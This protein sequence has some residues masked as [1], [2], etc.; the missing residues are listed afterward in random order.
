MAV[1]KAEGVRRWNYLTEE[2]EPVFY[3]V[4]SYEEIL[5]DI[6]N[7]NRESDGWNKLYELH[8]EEDR[9]Y[10]DMLDERRPSVKK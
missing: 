6:W 5:L 9:K 7:L 4:T 3:T 2:W 10:F 1:K 8:D